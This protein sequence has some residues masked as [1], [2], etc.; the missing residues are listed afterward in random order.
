MQLL[1]WGLNFKTVPVAIREQFA[2]TQDSIRSALSQW[3]QYTA[4]KEAVVLSTCN[5]SEVYAV[6][7]DDTDSHVLQTSSSPSCPASPT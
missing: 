1:V 7:D 6:C 2:A 3:D 5:R 4:L